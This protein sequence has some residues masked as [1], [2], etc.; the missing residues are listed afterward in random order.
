MR[1]F[2]I[3]VPNWCWTIFTAA[4]DSIIIARID[5]HFTFDCCGERKSVTSVTIKESVLFSRISDH[6]TWTSKEK[7]TLKYHKTIP[8]DWSIETIIDI[9]FNVFHFVRFI[10]WCWTQ[11]PQHISAVNLNYSGVCIFRS[12]QNNLN[13][14]QNRV[15]LSYHTKACAR[16]NA[17][18]KY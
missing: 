18:P 11:Y 14:N 12:K 17:K 10:H 9:Q 6:K 15:T 3:H 13:K 8:I 16:D 7:S 5:S 2:R 4:S 1:R